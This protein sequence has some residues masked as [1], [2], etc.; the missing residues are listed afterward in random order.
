MD[1]STPV[2]GLLS[3]P[4]EVLLRITDHL[5][6]PE[7]GYLRVSCKHMENMLFHTFSE[8]FF[9]R[10]Q[11]MLLEFS[12][13]GLVDISKSRVGLFV[14][15]LQFSIESMMHN[16]WN[17]DAYVTGLYE[18][19]G[20]FWEKGQDVAMLTE[21]LC[22]LPNLE[23]VVIRDA[24]STRRTRD[25]PGCP[26][27]S[28][29]RA[30][31][32][33][34]GIIFGI[35]GAGH[36]S[37]SASRALKSILHAL[38]LAEKYPTGLEMISRR[39]SHLRGDGFAI[40]HD[41]QPVF[42]P[43]L[44]KLEKLHLC[45]SLTDWQ[46]RGEARDRDNA[47]SLCKFLSYAKNLKDLRINGDRAERANLDQFLAHLG[48]PTLPLEKG[49][50]QGLSLPNLESFSLGMA[51]IQQTD[52]IAVARTLAPSLRSLE[53]WK[54]IMER[55]NDAEDFFGDAD[56]DE[57]SQPQWARVCKELIKIPDFNPRHIMLGFL[58][59]H[60]SSG[61]R[62]QIEFGH[63]DNN[64]RAAYTGPDCKRYLQEMMPTIHYGR[65]V[66]PARQVYNDTDNGS[67][68]DEDHDDDEESNHDN[69]DD[70][71][72][73]DGDGGDND[74]LESDDLPNTTS[75]G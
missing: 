19:Q 42:L 3:V 49:G 58:Q 75:T 14:R 62:R 40:P 72:G 57:S 38:G 33:A 32:E 26:W 48:D 31:E 53:L 73:E 64:I 1:M 9:S 2:C 63:A 30:T 51:L 44:E 21:A 39:H 65:Q 46:T 6:T 68:D 70:D 15:R 61:R 29:G 10:K 11:F 52:L 13:Q 25:G 8:E 54:V 55:P 50:E 59:D 69:D 37:Q 66:Q 22:N 20:E 17:P 43:V 36:P 41:L 74:D 24:D 4:L 5:T 28:Y 71:Q 56:D 60:Y 7:L 45:V 16:I 12:L 27:R 35:M 23:E 67:D 47:F 34:N 18:R